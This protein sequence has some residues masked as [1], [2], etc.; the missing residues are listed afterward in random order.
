MLTIMRGI[1][2]F[3]WL[4]LLLY[5]YIF[6]KLLF[7]L[8][9]FIWW[10]DDNSNF[11]ISVCVVVCVCLFVKKGNEKYQSTLSS[12]IICNIM[13]SDKIKDLLQLFATQV[14]TKLETAALCLAK[15]LGQHNICKLLET[16][17]ISSVW[18]HVTMLSQAWVFSIQVMYS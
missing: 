6:N 2:Y 12:K 1:S 8:V 11:V 17:S 14:T 15:Y 18:Y 13:V 16:S 9:R 7:L 3:I 5:H 4:N 10:E